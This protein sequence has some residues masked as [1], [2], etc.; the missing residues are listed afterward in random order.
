[1]LNIGTSRLIPSAEY[2]TVMSGGRLRAEGVALLRA[3]I[4]AARARERLDA[5]GLVLSLVAQAISLLCGRRRVF[6]TFHA[7]VEQ[8][9]FPRQKAPR[10]GAGLLAALRA[11]AYDRLQQ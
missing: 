1:M 7:G 8:Q 10:A 9:F 5:E 3:R 4:P 6:L 2:E 11:V